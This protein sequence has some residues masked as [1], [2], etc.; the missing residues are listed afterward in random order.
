M[1]TLTKLNELT[2]RRDALEEQLGDMICQHKSETAH[3]GDS[4]PGAQVEIVAMQQHVAT[5]AKAIEA[6]GDSLNFKVEP[7]HH[8]FYATDDDTYDGT[9]PSG[10]GL[11]PAD[12]IQDL[13]GALDAEAEALRGALNG[14]GIEPLSKNENGD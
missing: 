12:A 9:G 4:W 11:E 10:W 7:A 8:G 6:E 13:M 3:Y 14:N 2:E 1:K 5:V